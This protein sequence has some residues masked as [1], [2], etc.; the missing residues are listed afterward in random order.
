MSSDLDELK[1]RLVDAHGI[2]Y[3]EGLH[4]HFQ[5]HVS[6]RI[7]GKDEFLAP[8][9]VHVYGRGLED[10]SASDLIRFDLS[11]QK[12]EGDLSP[13]YELVIHSAILSSRKDVQSV[14]HCHSPYSIMLSV[15]EK[16]VLPV[17]LF[18]SI[19][20]EGVPVLDLGPSMVVSREHGRKLVQ[21]LGDKY[22]V[23]LRGHGAVIAGESV[24]HACARAVMLEFNAK[25]QVFSS[26]LGVPIAF[27]KGQ[28]RD[29]ANDMWLANADQ[30]WKYLRNKLRKQKS[31]Q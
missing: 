1:E 16:E 10:V 26:G 2:L 3:M 15:V 21:T 9:K 28:A 5:G 18:G 23:L 27:E 6:A 8:G 31:K 17:T 30:T 13:V 4:E 22:A 14:I 11:G 12:L 19:F 25:I 7:P 20:Y 29:N 24:E